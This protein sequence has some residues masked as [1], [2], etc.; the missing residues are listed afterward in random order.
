[1]IV[2]TRSKVEL[3][4]N[5]RPANFVHELC[6]FFTGNSPQNLQSPRCRVLYLS[7]SH[8]QPI[9]LD[10]L[11]NYGTV[12]LYGFK[13]SYR[14]PDATSPWRA[15]ISPPTLQYM[16]DLRG[17]GHTLPDLIKTW[18]APQY[19]WPYFHTTRYWSRNLV[20]NSW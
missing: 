1:M 4:F 11:L 15:F 12:S 6:H 17:E 16:I 7:R 20:S 14:V 2:T 13:G 8:L 10:P 3:T 9:L 5:S 19:V 18:M